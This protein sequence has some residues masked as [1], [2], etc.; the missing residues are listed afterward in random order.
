MRLLIDTLVAL[1]LCAVLGV[2]LWQQHHAAADEQRIDQVRAALREL[3]EQV[4]Y[5]AALD[6]LDEGAP[7][8]PAEVSPVWFSRRLP[9]N[10]LAPGAHAW[11]D[12]APEGDFSDHPPDPVLEDRS[13]AGFWYNP[14]FGIVRARVPAQANHAATLDLYNAVNGTVLDALPTDTLT[15]RH[16]AP[17]TAAAPSAYADVSFYDDTTA[18]QRRRPRHSR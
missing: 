12:V 4:V 15:V 11:V 2:V 3:R 18:V 9:W 13:Q 1:M 14:T 5:Q 17:I 6:Q 7:E 8:H 10:T 16:P